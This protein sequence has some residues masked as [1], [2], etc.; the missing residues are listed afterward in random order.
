MKI[1]PKKK[2]LIIILSSIF[3]ILVTIILCILFFPN[4]KP[5]T[6][7][8]TN[9]KNVADNR[10]FFNGISDQI[11][12]DELHATQTHLSD[13]D[14]KLYNL[15]FF[16]EREHPLLKHDTDLKRFKVIAEENSDGTEKIKMMSYFYTVKVE[17][18]D[19]ISTIESDLEI[20]D[21]LMTPLNPDAG[22]YYYYFLQTE[23][24]GMWQIDKID[25]EVVNVLKQDA[26]NNLTILIHEAKEFDTYVM[27]RAKDGLYE[28]LVDFTPK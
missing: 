13:D 23:E 24:K 19:V 2:K 11:I 22:N 7:P 14:G 6:N 26:I 21:S 27:I 20:I 8:S 9:T 10:E 12:T 28:I 1:T 18:K 4:K 15:Y 3:L 17:E 5:N 25:E 16:N